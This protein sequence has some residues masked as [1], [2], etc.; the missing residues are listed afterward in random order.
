[1]PYIKG[2]AIVGFPFELVDIGGTAITTGAVTGYYLLDGGAQTA[3]TGAATHE[4]NGQWS[5]DTIPATATDGTTLGLLFLHA[6]G[7]ASF[8]VQLADTPYGELIAGT[9]S[10]VALCNLALDELGVESIESLLDDSDR[11]RRLRRLYPQARDEM[12][13]VIR[14][15]CAIRRTL[16]AQ[17]T[18]P[19]FGYSYAHQLPTGCLTALETDNDG[20]TWAREND[21][22]VTDRT[23]VYL[24]YVYR[25]EDVTKYPPKF[26]RALVAYMA[27][28]LAYP[29]TKSAALRDQMLKD[30]EY[31]KEEALAL[32]GQ[33]GTADLLTNTVLTTDVRS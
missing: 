31:A 28:R 21:T 19:T 23:P 27:A 25:L 17:T 22:L 29:I 3:L 16:L 14:P 1:M 30:F 9:P 10:E 26:S 33:E 15:G 8:T 24:K 13:D 5:W 4:G 20:Y 2:Q 11:A 18:T 7:R 6:S 12:L 32:E